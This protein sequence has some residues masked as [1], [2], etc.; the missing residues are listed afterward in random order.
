V[1][2]EK[3]NR[4]LGAAI[5]R[6]QW[7]IWSR[8]V[9]VAEATKRPVFFY[10]IGYADKKGQRGYM[11]AGSK[12]DSRDQ[13][14]VQKIAND[15]YKQFKVIPSDYVVIEM[16]SVLA[17]VRRNAEKAGHD[18]GA[19]FLPPY[20]DPRLDEVLK[21]YDSSLPE[22]AIV[23]TDKSIKERADLASRAGKK[24]RGAFEAMLPQSGLLSRTLKRLRT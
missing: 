20:G 17:N 16:Q 19:A 1:L 22:R 15:I 24:A 3:L 4:T 10:V 14:N 23:V 8:V 11:T 21:P 6:D 2:A 12:L 7:G 5:V 9:A 18:F 13:D